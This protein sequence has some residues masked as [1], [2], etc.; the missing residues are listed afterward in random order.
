M[1][2]ANRECR[3]KGVATST[4]GSS[5]VQTVRICLPCRRPRLDY[6][7]GKIPSKKGMAIHSSI[8]AWRIPWTGEPGELPSVGLQRVKHNWATHK[9]QHNATRA[10]FCFKVKLGENDIS[11]WHNFI[12]SIICKNRIHSGYILCNYILSFTCLLL[13]FWFI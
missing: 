10:G 8:L 11:S 4:H 3:H 9:L 5:L 6:W 1:V 7:A 2:K 13:S 12:P